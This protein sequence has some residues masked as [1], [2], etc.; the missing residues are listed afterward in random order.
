MWRRQEDPKVSPSPQNVVVTPPPAP[1]A[2]V[3]RPQVVEPVVPKTA[4]SLVSKGISINGQ[5]TGSE[6]IQV[7]GEVHGSLRL[8]GNRVLIGQ[9]GR[10]TGDIEAREIVVR[11]TLKGNLRASERILVGHTGR[12]KG[13]STS[14]RL[15]I[16]EGAVVSGNL[17]VAETP[18]KK[19][20]RPAKSAIAAPIAAP[21][22]IGNGANLSSTA[23]PAK[24]SNGSS[25]GHE[26]VVAAVSS[27]TENIV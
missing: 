12:W 3:T 22:A 26:P 8:G 13:N 7:D 16:E 19:S 18:E 27:G 14:P 2:P 24:G 20:D 11:G 6:D 10:V 9:D 15:V 17:E 23:V 4:L 1:V 25:N 21:P 5:V